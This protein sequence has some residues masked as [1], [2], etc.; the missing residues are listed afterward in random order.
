MKNRRKIISGI[1]LACVLFALFSPVSAEINPEAVSIVSVTSIKDEVFPGENATYDIKVCSIS[2]IGDPMEHVYL[3]I[4]NPKAG[5]IYSFS[6]E[7]F[8]INASETKRSLLNITVPDDATS[9]DYCH[10]INATVYLAGYEF[11]GKTS[12]TTF[13]NVKTKVIPIL[14]SCDISGNEKNQ[15]A[16]DESVYVRGSGFLADTN[17]SIWIQNDPVNEGDELNTA[18]DPSL[19]Q[20]LVK[21]NE[22]GSFDPIEIWKIPEGAS[23]TYDNWDIVADKQDDDDNTRYY[24]SASDG[25][26]SFD[27]VGFVAPVPEPGTLTMFSMGLIVLLGYVRLKGGKNTIRDRLSDES[28]FEENN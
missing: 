6:P 28:W 20:E 11:L 15:F 26:D 25:I 16:P 23:V 2:K 17:Y 9:G 5:W 1:F 14:I 24:N 22:T 3:A 18:E 21:T 13:A 12:T 7:D 19:L 4:E 27:E 8:M 10:I